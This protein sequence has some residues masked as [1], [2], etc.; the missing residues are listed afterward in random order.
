[1]PTGVNLDLVL[2]NRGLFTAQPGD[3]VVLTLGP[4]VSPLLMSV[5]CRTTCT[6]DLYTSQPLTAN[7]SGSRAT[8]RATLTVPLRIDL[9]AAINCAATANAYLRNDLISLASDVA[10]RTAT[11]TL[12]STWQFIY[13]S[14]ACLVTASTSLTVLHVS[15]NGVIRFSGAVTSTVDL[16][17]PNYLQTK[18]TAPW[19]QTS[20]N[21]TT[22]RGT[23]WR[24]AL[25]GVIGHGGDQWRDAALLDSHS[26]SMPW[27][28]AAI[29]G[30]AIATTTWRDAQRVPPYVIFLPWQQARTLG[31]YH[32]DYSWKQGRYL[33]THGL[34]PWRQAANNDLY[35]RFPWDDGQHVLS[36]GGPPFKPPST[37]KFIRTND[38][39]F[40]HPWVYK[41]PR[42]LALVLGDPT[43]CQ[44]LTHTI[45]VKGTYYVSNTVTLK[46]V[47]DNTPI[48]ITN[49]QVGTDKTTFC[50]SFS[51]NIPFSEI[52]KVEPSSSGAV[53]VEL[54]INAQVWRFFIE[55]YSRSRTFGQD[56]YTIKG[57][58]PSAI[59]DAPYAAPRNQDYPI[60][61]FSQ[62]MADAEL[63][64]NF[65]DTGF[66][67]S[68]ELGDSPGFLMPAGAWS[69]TNL[70]PIAAI[71]SMASEWGAFLN[72]DTSAKVLRMIPWYPK[73]WWQWG[74]LTPEFVIPESFIRSVQLSYSEKPLYTGVSIRGQ[75]TGAEVVVTID[76]SD[77]LFRAAPVVNALIGHQDAARLRAIKVLGEG[78]KQAQVTMDLPL[79]STYGLVKPGMMVRITNGGLGS[80]PPWLGNVNSTSVHASW[81]NSLQVIQ[82]IGVERHYGVLPF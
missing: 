70:T 43:P 14:L 49:A 42:T 30:P 19:G 67:L 39:V 26:T 82:T 41:N 4:R 8:A 29:L 53:L 13:G 7:V 9:A 54:T 73:P 81:Q 56:Q 74:T 55:D 17:I 31:R 16:N 61:F 40:C 60:D 52:S 77:G 3:G 69:Y 72:S 36:H 44:L 79:D 23:V 15:V 10:C 62:Q 71:S 22:S 32:L 75:S 76:G 45:P 20:S 48:T 66:T 37:F 21:V 5:V 51:G 34:F 59:L 24:D 2:G 28:Q 11:N 64:R 18:F 47:D 50:W 25:A 46:R 68:Y 58:S 80:E 78:G 57:R 1:M 27:R 33:P 12:L 38:L 65:L 35:C 63:S 6:A